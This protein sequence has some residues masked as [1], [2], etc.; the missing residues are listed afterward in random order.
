MIVGPDPSGCVISDLIEVLLVILRSPLI[1]HRS[2]EPLDVGVLLWLAWLYVLEGNARF[3][4]PVLDRT[5]DVLRA[6]VTAD[7]QGP[8]SPLNDLF[9]G[10]DNPLRRQRE[11]DLHTQ[12]LSVVVIGDV[13]HSEAS[14]IRELVVH[15]VHRPDL[16]DCLGYSQWLWLFSVQTLPGLDPKIEL[17]SLVNPID[18]LVIPFKALDVTQVE[19]T[20][21][22]PPVAVVIRQA[23]Q[24]VGDLLVLSIL[25]S[26]VPITGLTH[27]ENHTGQP[28]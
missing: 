13:E 3:F 24:P 8:A 7:N 27:R 5:T 22:E 9:E 21:T 12:G 18:P 11:V 15:K 26:L 10:T 14:S 4:G 17:Q 2:V 16:I 19:V 6:I 28:D 20:E 25:L 1:T 23:Q